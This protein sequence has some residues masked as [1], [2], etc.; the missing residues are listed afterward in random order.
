MRGRP[1]G[2]LVGR[3]RELAALVEV[4]ESAAAGQA[5]PC[6][7][8]GEAGI[9]K[10]ALVAAAINAARD[11]GLTILAGRADDLERDRPFGPLADA[12]GLDA[13]SPDPRSARAAALLA[14]DDS[15][16]VVDATP[17]VSELLVTLV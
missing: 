14:G 10:T 6:V 7:V 12:L 2:G 16:E 8:E 17:L 13:A 4:V 3:D 1:A 5:R 11:R 9:G 15:G